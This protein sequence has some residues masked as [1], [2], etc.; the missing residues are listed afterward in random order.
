MRAARTA[1][2]SVS[3]SYAPWWRRPLMKKL[4]VPATPLASAL[5][6]SSATRS[7]CSRP[8]Q[9][10]PEALDVEAELLRVALEVAHRQLVLGREQPVVHRPERPL[11]ARR[12]GRLGGHLRVA[13]GRR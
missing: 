4:G 7:A 3:T 11:R 10:V 6:T 12:L 8:P 2:L 5:A 9:L 1:A 13:G